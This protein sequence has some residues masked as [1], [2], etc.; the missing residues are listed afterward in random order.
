[1]DQDASN[2]TVGDQELDQM[3]AN[4]KGQ[5]VVPPTIVN[6]GGAPIS[7]SDGSTVS[8]GQDDAS[9]TA[10]PPAPSAPTID[11]AV[12]VS[13]ASAPVSEPAV[14]APEPKP[15]PAPVTPSPANPPSN[16]ADIKRDALAE[17]RPLADK[18]DLPPEEK[19]TT[20]LLIIR[21]TDDSSLLSAAHMAAQ[22]ITDETK[23][24]AALLDVIK[25]VDFFAQQAR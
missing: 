10:A 16:L 25:E 11:P 22:A 18:L 21:S 17:L 15:E 7:S 2:S 14:P 6:S 8:N 13:D 1:M 19:F 12:S 24:A 20:L 23:R 5:P 3:I 9:G 4:I